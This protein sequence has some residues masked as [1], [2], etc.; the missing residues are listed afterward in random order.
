M[1]AVAGRLPHRLDQG[2][3]A[4]LLAQRRDVHV[5]GLGRAVP[6]GVP[7]IAQ[8]PGPIDDDPGLGSEQRQEVEFLHGQLELAPVER[9]ASRRDVDLERADR[10]ESRAV[11]AAGGAARTARIRATSSRSPKGLT[12]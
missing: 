9:C 2:R 6:G 8:D 12:T 4:Q 11:R 1:R 5:D 3:V 7:D 10:E